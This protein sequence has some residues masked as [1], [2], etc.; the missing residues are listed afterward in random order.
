ML[1]AYPL[2]FAE[3]GVDCLWFLIGF[4]CKGLEVSWPSMP[5]PRRHLEFRVQEG[6]LTENRGQTY[7][8]SKYPYTEIT[9]II[10]VTKQFLKILMLGLERWLSG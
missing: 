7:E 2:F 8:Q 5:S 3:G 6:Q 10:M 1:S 9:I 4:G